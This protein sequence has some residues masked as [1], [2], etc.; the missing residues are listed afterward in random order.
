MP[1]GPKGEKRPADP[2][3]N[4]L[5]VAKI[6]VGDA[7]ET[8]VSKRRQGGLKGGVVRASKLSAAR[9]SEIARKAAAARW[10]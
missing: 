6:A 2:V 8:H 1:T 4:A 10:G 3:A 9:R 5:L 7:E